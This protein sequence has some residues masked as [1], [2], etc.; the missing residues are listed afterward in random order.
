MIFVGRRKFSAAGDVDKM[1]ELFPALDVGLNLGDQLAEFFGGH[2]RARLGV[3]G[4]VRG[5]R[6]MTAPPR[7]SR[8]VTFRLAKWML[9][10]ASGNCASRA[11]QWS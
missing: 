4:A 1:V 2:R 5:E 6:K 11:W 9:N 8:A 10:S 3:A 7:I